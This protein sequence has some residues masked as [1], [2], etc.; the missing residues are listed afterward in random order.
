MT[1]VRHEHRL[2][3]VSPDLVA[4][5]R[6]AAE[7]MPI[8]VIEGV[9]T[10]KRQ[11]ELYAQGRNGDPRPIVTW[12]MASK[13]ITGQA[14]DI[15]PHPLDWNDRKAFLALAGAMFAAA[16]SL[17]VRIRWG[18]DFDMDGKIMERG[19][20]DLVHFETV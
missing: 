16:Q 14:V 6:R 19:E 15:G 10:A 18:G 8:T 2:T 17:G 3:G 13:H 20:A 5:V 11:A 9:R 1:A 7:I 12:T 4:V